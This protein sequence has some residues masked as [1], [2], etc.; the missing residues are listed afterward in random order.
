MGPLGPGSWVEL[1]RR[2]V[3]RR[4]MLSGMRVQALLL[5][6]WAVP[7]SANRRVA[8]APRLESPVLSAPNL[9]REMAPVPLAAAD[10]VF[11]TV[12]DPG[13]PAL[14]LARPEVVVSAREE[15]VLAAL[16]EELPETP[17]DRLLAR[18]AARAVRIS[19]GDAGAM[20]EAARGPDLAAGVSAGVRFFDL[21]VQA[22]DTDGRSIVAI[23]DDNPY[24]APR[25]RLMR[26]RDVQ[27]ERARTAW[28]RRQDKRSSYMLARSLLG[29]AISVLS[30][31]VMIPIY[32]NLRASP[33]PAV[34]WLA[35]LLSS[36]ALIFLAFLFSLSV[37][38]SFLAWLT[39]R[40][41]RMNRL[42]RRQ[43]L[44]G[45]N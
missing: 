1:L 34:L 5:L 12:L 18:S 39:L 2:S 32:E 16:A 37:A 31:H 22:A 7:A 30:A 41:T 44:A 42:D 19:Q 21:G 28:L 23:D 3:G 25:T 45:K 26:I 9:G 11:P 29:G 38:M 36:L 35:I 43:A 17:G 13:T 15:P 8:P 10:T 40:L 6:A 33:P 20:V 14:A 4:S 27:K 24:R